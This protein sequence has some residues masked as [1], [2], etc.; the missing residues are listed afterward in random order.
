MRVYSLGSCF[1]LVIDSFSYR[2]EKPRR[3]A[4]ALLQTLILSLNDWYTF[5]FLTASIKSV[6]PECTLELERNERGCSKLIMY[7]NNFAR[8][9]YS[10]EYCYNT[11]PQQ[12]DLV[13]LRNVLLT[14]IH[15]SRFVYS[16]TVPR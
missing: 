2:V 14:V 4:V 13:S 6:L 8:N 5:K 7:S 3:R 16:T 1:L 12:T 9:L 10:D 11:F 15:E